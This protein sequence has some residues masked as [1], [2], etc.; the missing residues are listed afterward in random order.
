MR[1]VLYA[2]TTCLIFL[3]LGLTYASGQQGMFTRYPIES[4]LS[5]SVVNCLYQDPQGFIWA[6]TQNG[7]DRFDGYRF[8]IFNSKPSDT[9]TLS[10]NWIYAIAG[11]SSGNLWIG[12]KNGLN[13]YNQQENRFRRI[14]WES[15]VAGNLSSHVYDVV[16]S[17]TGAI[18]LN[19]PPVLTIYDPSKGTFQHFKGPL[20]YDG[21]VNDTRIPLM[22]DRDGRIWC[23]STR[24]LTC[25]DLKTGTTETYQHDPWNR[26]SLSHATITAL[27]ED[28]SGDLWIGTLGG[29]DRFSRK[30]K[31]IERILTAGS[32]G[33]TPF[34]TVRA[35][36]G[37]GDH[38]I[39]LGT[40]GNG[41]YSIE[42]RGGEIFK[43]RQFTNELHGLGHN[44][45]LSLLVDKSENLWA[46][47]LQGLART[48]LKPPK[49]N[50]YR[51]A[52]TTTPVHLLGNVIASVY[53]DSS[54]LVW[55]GNWGQGLNIIDRRN[56]G[57]EHFSTNMKGRNYIPNDYV[58]VIFPAEQ[59]AIWIGTRD[60]ILVF[61]R[62]NH[63]FVRIN[64]YYRDK[65]LPNLS[66][67][68]I[69]QILHASDN[70]YWIATQNGLYRILPGMMRFEYYSVEQ[71]LRRRLSGNLVYDL[72]E[73]S[74]HLIWIATLGGVDVLNPVTQEIKHFRNEPGNPNSL[75]DDFVTTLCEDPRG[76]I[77]IGT[78]SYVNRFSKTDS[79]FHYYTGAEGFPDNLV[80]QILRD[81]AGDLWF[82]TG[83]GLCRFEPESGRFRTFTVED[84][85]QSREFNLHAGY[86]S[87][88]GELF[89]GGMNG[90]NSFFPEKMADNPY[91]PEI[92]LTACYRT[93]GSERI[94]LDYRSGK[95]VLP[96]NHPDL[97]IEFAALEFTNPEEN[98]FAYILEGVSEEWMETGTRN[99]V[100]FPGLSP[101]TYLLRVKGSNNDGLWNESR[102]TLQIVIRP[103][104]WRTGY[105]FGGYLIIFI[106]LILLFIR[107]R[108]R[109]LVRERN[110]LEEKVRLRTLKIEE[111][112]RELTS[113]NTTKDKFFS[114]IAHDLRNP[115]NT[116]LGISEMTIG[117]L[118][119]EVPGKVSKSIFDIRDTARHAFD[120]LQNLLIWARSQTN[121]LEF[122]PVEFDLTG[123]I[124][125]N[126]DLVKSQASGKNISIIFETENPVQVTGDIRMIDTLLRNLLTNAI[127]FTPKHGKITLVIA[128]SD[129]GTEVSVYD[130][131]VGI[132]AENLPKLFRLD[133]KYTRK[134][135][136]Q[137]RG[138]GLGLILC[139]EF[140]E[141]HGGEIWV[142]SEP[143][144][145]SR[146]AFS[147]PA[148]CKN[149]EL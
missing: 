29:L 84:G 9:N 115:F 128:P 129:N 28:A 7:L 139:K 69:F 8:R 4:G 38:Q 79:M 140:I 145:G 14:L 36:T 42:L 2:S 80:Y 109:N 103:P 56:G 47:T 60:G 110:L 53:K 17:E 45:V 118:S 54:G 5:Q 1:S 62:K 71:E 33:R 132:P 25:F 120:L 94:P 131:G 68:R 113:L 81:K 127:K 13:F 34:R 51:T 30:S 3:L 52:G 148:S 48:D 125:E 104:W 66:E 95:V 99:F 58:H 57:V 15:P 121:S 90:F 82:G 43:L 133:S 6:G 74:Q 87:S 72:I 20:P 144:K 108:E 102:Q 134:G 92:V 101:G 21:A 142:E 83:N 97:T 124:R 88:D 31:T 135:T 143:G 39:W 141:K 41:L 122:Q 27:F 126:I 85:L 49:F 16:V 136:D 50:L 24:G 19:T 70:S 146:F 117:N 75:C 111:Q 55:A 114:I 11:D 44:I 89:T 100:N 112:N 96:Y 149:F 105:A 63:H 67:T 37:S 106:L 18:L 64:Q 93:T 32:D 76:D 116:I 26:N 86:C 35:I 73:D 77:W 10:N 22:E 98:R 23:G 78:N 61:D 40:E 12:T 130:T 107:I 138:S 137:E 65:Q 59:G 123:R 91:L 147:L 46:G 119:P